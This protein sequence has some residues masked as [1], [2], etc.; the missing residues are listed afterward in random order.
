MSAKA[1]L[2]KLTKKEIKAIEEQGGNIALAQEGK[3]RAFIEVGG[4]ILNPDAL[5][6]LYEA[7]KNLRHTV[8]ALIQDGTIPLNHPSIVKIT[9]QS[10]EALWAINKVEGK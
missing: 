7:L 8:D 9:M 1:E 3:K 10:N 2:W 5:P 4:V 6:D